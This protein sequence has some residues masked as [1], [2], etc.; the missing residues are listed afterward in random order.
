M[1]SLRLYFDYAQHGALSE[2]SRTLSEAEM[3]FPLSERSRTLSEAEMS[4]LLSERS[5]TLSGV[6][7]SLLLPK[8][9]MKTG[10]R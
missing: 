6:E 4:F 2:R 5:Q 9:C 1:C 7:M 10:Q 8:I 3:S